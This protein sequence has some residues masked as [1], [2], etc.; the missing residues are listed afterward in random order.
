MTKI[1]IQGAGIVG[2]STELFLKKFVPNV[3]ISFNDPYKEISP[4]A[5][6]WTEADY[7]IVCVNTDLDE[8][9]VLPENNTKNVNDAIN[10]ALAKGF[11]G[12]MVV[13][14][15][16]GMSAI[17]DYMEQLGQHLLV[18]PEYIR[19]ATWQEDSVN[20]RFVVL[21]GEPAEAFADLLS[22]YQG[23]A[24]ITDPMEA[25]IAKLSTNTFL[26]MKVIFA[27]QVE[28]MCK[29]VGADYSI[30]RVMLEN[31]GRLGSSHWSVPGSD[32]VAGFSGKCF[33]KDVKTFE[34]A[35]VKSGIHVDLIRAI[36]DLNNE[37]R[38]NVKE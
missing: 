28:Q 16:L 5:S 10:E 12:T 8:S 13:R 2:Q 35:L 18:W 25:M 22:A 36:T 20:P 21:G 17:K 9:L 29:A 19:E 11:T 7:V 1:I 15:T 6:D 34:T 27:N 31:E 37:M 23:P 33:P 38:T 14:S 32:G 3:Q 24:F 4:L 26:A 30:V